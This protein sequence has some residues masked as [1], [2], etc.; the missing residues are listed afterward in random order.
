[1]EVD[2]PLAANKG[3]KV[4]RHPVQCVYL[5][6][7]NKSPKQDG[8][9]FAHVSNQ[10][11]MTG[12]GWKERAGGGTCHHLDWQLARVYG[13]AKYS[14]YMTY[15]FLASGFL[16][17]YLVSSYTWISLCFIGT[18]KKPCT[19]MYMTIYLS[20]CV[21]S[22]LPTRFPEVSVFLHQYLAFPATT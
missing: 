14:R 6:F 21:S 9:V 16:D 1:M 18:S 7:V 13:E 3:S 20:I 5:T 15:C 4:A 17:L 19:N 12:H 11:C 22:Y 2:G 8:R 10:A